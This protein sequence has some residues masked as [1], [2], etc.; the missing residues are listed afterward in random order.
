[1]NVRAAYPPDLPDLAQTRREFG[2]DL[3]PLPLPTVPVHPSGLLT[4][5]PPPP[6]DRTGWPWTTQS[7]PLPPADTTVRLTIVTPAFQH[8]R[9][10]EETIRSVLLQNH[11]NLEYIIIDGGSTDE[12]RSILERY[13]PWL[14]FQ[15]S[16]PDHGQG[17]AI[18]RG[19]ALASGALRGWLNSDD[20]YLPGALHALSTAAAE[21]SA[22][23]FFYGDGLELDERTGHVR[24]ALAPW[25]HARYLAFGGIVFSH[26]AFWR[27]EIH[28]PIW[29]KMRCNVDGELWQRLLPG[30]CLQY[31]PQPLGLV[32]IQPEAKTV[33]PRHHD[34]WA[35]DAANY[36]AL[37]GRWPRA[38]SWLGYEHR[39]VQRFM[40]WR[41]S[42]IARPQRAAVLAACQWP[43][44]P[45]LPGAN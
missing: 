19:F 38:R 29:E 39:Y 27:A 44:L 2:V 8:G 43:Q 30:R 7:E 10:L 4:V 25:V 34:A 14:S 40:A 37:H 11:P 18:N 20:C 21:S 28:E 24:Y 1:V 12:T 23:Q 15:Y 36:Q 41:R 26:A 17:H 3:P 42:R 6:P 16:A 45:K 13:S 35:E 22:A 9:Y 33:H 5:L 32:R 31:L